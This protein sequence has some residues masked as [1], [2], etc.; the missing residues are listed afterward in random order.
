MPNCGKISTTML[1]SGDLFHVI[2]THFRGYITAAARNQS[3]L[4]VKHNNGKSR[5]ADE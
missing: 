4:W 1:L 2:F 5:C 3:E